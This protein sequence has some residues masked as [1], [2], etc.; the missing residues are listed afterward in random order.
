MIFFNPI[1]A[2]GVIAFG[3]SRCEA[4]YELCSDVTMPQDR[5][6]TEQIGTVVMLDGE[7]CV[8]EEVVHYFYNHDP[9]MVADS[10]PDNTYTIDKKRRCIDS[11]FVT[12]TRFKK[13]LVRRLVCASGRNGKSTIGDDGTKSHNETLE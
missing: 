5:I 13:P 4:C 2:F 8:L 7:K 1:T 3:C 6:V 12:A 10:L 11:V 9:G